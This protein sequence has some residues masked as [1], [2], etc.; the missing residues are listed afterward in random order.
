[1]RE[2]RKNRPGR[3]S[4]LSRAVSTAV[5]VLA[6]T[7]LTAHGLVFVWTVS[8]QAFGTQ[9]RGYNH[10]LGAGDVWLGSYA[11]TEAGYG[12]QYAYC[13]GQA[14]TPDPIG[15]TSYG[16]TIWLDGSDGDAITGSFNGTA[17]SIPVW[18]D[19]LRQSGPRLDQ[20]NTSARTQNGTTLTGANLNALGYVL[21]KW[22]D[23]SDNETARRVSIL[24]REKFEVMYLSVYSDYINYPSGSSSEDVR[25]AAIDAMWAEAHAN[26]GPYDTTAQAITVDA[27]QRGGDLNGIGFLS[28]AGNMQSGYAWTATIT[29]GNAEWDSNNSSILTGTTTAAYQTAGFHVVDGTSGDVEILVVYTD[30]EDYRV[31]YRNGSPG[32]YQDVIWSESY[33]MAE[34][35]TSPIP[36]QDTF[37]FSIDTTTSAVTAAAGDT[38]TDELVVTMERGLWHPVGQPVVVTSTLYGPL[39]AVPALSATV[40]GG[41]P[42]V[43]SVTTTI[44][45]AGTYTTPG[46]VVPTNG[47][48][49]W[50]ETSPFE[51][52]VVDAWVSEFGRASEITVVPWDPEATTA[53]G[54]R[55]AVPGESIT[56]EVTVTGGQPNTTVDVTLDLYLHDGTTP[57]TEGAIPAGATLLDTGSISVALNGS[58]T[59]T[60]TGTLDVP[61]SVDPGYL[62]VVATVE[63]GTAWNEWTSDYGIAAETA[64]VQWSPAAT[65]DAHREWGN[66][67]V[68][69][70][71]AVDFPDD[72]GVLADETEPITVELFF[73]GQEFTGDLT[74]QCTPANRIGAVTVP[75]TNGTHRASGGTFDLPDWATSDMDGTYLFLHS[76]PGSE[77]IAAFS[78][79]C[80]EPLETLALVLTDY[81]RGGLADTGADRLTAYASASVGM[82]FAGVLALVWRRRLNLASERQS[83]SA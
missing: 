63:S 50:A 55:F 56:D 82:L 69:M 65:T 42:V 29:S 67:M 30:V 80:G 13:A 19:P 6:V 62:T 68:D 23:T 22:G 49:V 58:G 26:A 41:T 66:N 73:V 53:L 21:S 43:G 39:D 48:Y 2:T 71:E 78:G 18:S 79:T 51:D 20:P 44:T 33:N 38:I 11:M 16:A 70:V 28:A 4:A 40:P 46:I 24:I 83:I 36:V 7:V 34:R 60:N 3:K 14:A 8:A 59:G 57:P 81:N 74:T 37:E 76:H 47:I 27:D 72:Y 10:N 25:R 32:N 5:S 54:S 45:A 75:A 35:A 15:A 9:Y 77:R 52:D 17:P 1:M 64:V 61:G 31:G 12:T